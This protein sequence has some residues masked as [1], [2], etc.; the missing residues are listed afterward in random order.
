M[1]GEALD[2]QEELKFNDRFPHPIIGKGGYARRK[3]LRPNVS[4]RVT[5]DNPNPKTATIV[6]AKNSG[7]EIS[8]GDI[9]S[10]FI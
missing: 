3:V 2:M 4:I 7:F 1:G 8:A 5:I 9:A 10:L 6:H